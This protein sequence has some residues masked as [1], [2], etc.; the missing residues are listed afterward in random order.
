MTK[1][2]LLDLNVKKFVTILIKFKSLEEIT[3]I[4]N[5]L[6][7][8]NNFQFKISTG[9]VDNSEILKKNTVAKLMLPKSNVTTKKENFLSPKI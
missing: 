6:K 2:A 4:I 1:L 8:S 7:K 3:V 9:I 5:N